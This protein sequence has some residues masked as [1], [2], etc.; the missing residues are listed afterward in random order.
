MRSRIRHL[1]MQRT[2]RTRSSPPRAH[3]VEHQHAARDLASLHRAE[4]LVDV[5]EAATASDHLVEEQ[6]AL[7]IEV[8]VAGDVDAEAVAAHAGGLHAPPGAVG[9]AGKLFLRF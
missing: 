6:A 2:S 8:E 9:H 4:G 1:R 3:S 7:A 5:V